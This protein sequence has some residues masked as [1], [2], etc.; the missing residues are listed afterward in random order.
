[1]EGL[2]VKCTT[3]GGVLHETTEK[4][5]PNK[6]LNGSMVRLIYPWKSWGWSAFDDE[7]ANIS[8]TPAV[9]M[10]CPN[11]S[12]PLVKNGKLTIVE[13]IKS[14]MAMNQEAMNGF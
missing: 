14:R 3:C 6:T 5:D 2:K 13:D 10:C 12:A 9:L 8:T 11:C 1:M 4:Y 7:T